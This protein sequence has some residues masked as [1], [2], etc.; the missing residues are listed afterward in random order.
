[1]EG[2]LAV[3]QLSNPPQLSDVSSLNLY[4]EDVKSLRDCK[5][6]KC[7]VQIT[8]AGLEKIQN[9]V[10]WSD[11]DVDK[12]VNAVIR[13]M[14]LEAVERYNA[15]GNDALGVYI[16]KESP[17][18]VREHI[19]NLLG[20]ADF[21]P[22]LSPELNT[23]LLDYPRAELPGSEDI[24]YWEN[25]KFGLKPT[26]RLNHMVIY[27]V[28]LEPNSVWVVATKQLY[29]SHYFYTALDM[30]FCVK[31]TANPNQEGF[32]LITLKG[33][34]QDGL[35][36]FTGSILRSVVTRKTRS[37]MESALNGIKKRL[38]GGD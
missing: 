33:S 11:P 12:K 2:Y 24:F 4:S 26:L 28:E 3:Q 32:Y 1:V 8:D 15:G 27:K 14:V 9:S 31:D 17:L 5:E 20:R 29:A 25:V 23:Y 21:L 18:P 10:D 37:S 38:E 30:N 7:D 6:K 34:R 19:E 36:G 13:P 22:V 16:D 35:T